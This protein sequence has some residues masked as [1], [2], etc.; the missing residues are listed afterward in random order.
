MSFWTVITQ[1][2]ADPAHQ[3][4]VAA[5]LCAAAVGFAGATLS[6]I[7]ADG[8]SKGCKRIRAKHDADTYAT[9]L[10]AKY[11]YGN[12]EPE[13]PAVRRRKGWRLELRE[14]LFGGDS[15]WLDEPVVLPAT[16]E[17]P[18]PTSPEGGEEETSEE[19]NPVPVGPVGLP[20]VVEGVVVEAEPNPYPH[21]HGGMTEW[22]RE[23]AAELRALLAKAD[24]DRAAFLAGLDARE[25]AFRRG[26]DLVAA[27]YAPRHRE[28]PALDAAA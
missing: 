12:A 25:K 4:A 14:R 15:A 16:A 24:A 3:D 6:E 1:A 11:R 18:Q 8:E 21:I 13:Q 7:V 22:N 20:E 2:L 9:T 26:D 28:W 19:T 23:Q 17:A 5:L 27:G 10:P